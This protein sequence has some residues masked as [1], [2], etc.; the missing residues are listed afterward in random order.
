[1]T[2]A[3]TPKGRTLVDKAIVVRFIEAGEA[4]ASLSRTERAS[5]S[6]LLRKLGN[7]LRA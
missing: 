6:I 3:L 2:A 4:A 7:G 1:L 5:L